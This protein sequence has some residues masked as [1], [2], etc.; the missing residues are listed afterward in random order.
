VASEDDDLTDRQRDV[1]RLYR[2]AKSPTEIGRALQISSQGVHGHLRRL[3]QKG[4]I[5]PL[6]RAP[7][8]TT[9]EAAPSDERA[10]QRLAAS[11][12]LKTV[13]ETIAQQEQ[14][15]DSRQAAIREQ[16]A[17]LQ[18]E[19]EDLSAS[20][21]E[22][23]QMAEPHAEQTADEAAPKTPAKRANN[24]VGAPHKSAATTK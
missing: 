8:A 6:Q 2:E 15:I 3:R 18:A 11:L 20:K 24:G 7:R 21:R 17:E 14:L 10:R 23:A 12:A 4:L 13:H 1:L 9:A 22:L 5:E 19:Y 16:I